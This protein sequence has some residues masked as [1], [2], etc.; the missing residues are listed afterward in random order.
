M[1]FH[2]GDERVEAGSG[3]RVYGP[4]GVPYEFEAQGTAPT[5]MLLFNTPAGFEGF[6][7]EVGKP[8]KGLTLPPAGPSDLQKLAKIAAKY[9]IEIL[10][11]LPGR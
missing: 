7:V 1:T 9:D 4:R 11:P 5:R 10:A 3:A 2:V 6:P 8:A